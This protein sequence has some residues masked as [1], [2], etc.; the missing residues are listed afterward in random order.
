MADRVRTEGNIEG[1]YELAS[2]IVLRAI[3][4]VVDWHV[5]VFRKP[6]KFRDYEKYKDAVDAMEFLQD[7]G[8]LSLYTNYSPSD[9]MGFIRQK[10]EKRLKMKVGDLN[11]L[12]R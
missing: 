6:S 12:S 2:A 1:Y 10:V 11:N 8:R 7:E 9:V 5:E 3:D 4:D